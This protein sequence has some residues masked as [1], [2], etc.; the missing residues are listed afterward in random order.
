[1]SDDEINEHS[2]YTIQECTHYVTKIISNDVTEEIKG[3]FTHAQIFKYPLFQFIPINPDNPDI[4]TEENQICYGISSDAFQSF[5][6]HTKKSKIIASV[7]YVTAFNQDNCSGDLYH[8]YTPALL[9]YIRQKQSSNNIKNYITKRLFFPEQ[10]EIIRQEPTKKIE[11]EVCYY[12]AIRLAS[13]FIFNFQFDVLGY[14]IDQ[15][16][17]L[18]DTINMNIPSIESVNLYFHLR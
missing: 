11:F 16:L 3:F 13:D 18:R 2:D 10:S 14:K 4:E 1:M 7:G 6:N 8:Y 5:F 15:L 12:L 9:T 17:E